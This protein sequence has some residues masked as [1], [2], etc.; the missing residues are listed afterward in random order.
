MNHGKQAVPVCCPPG[1]GLSASFEATW[2]RP[3]SWE[4][5]GLCFAAEEGWRGSLGRWGPG[6]TL[7][8]W[9]GLWG[10]KIQELGLQGAA[11]LLWAFC[12][13]SHVGANPGLFKTIMV[14]SSL[15]SH[16]TQNTQSSQA[17]RFNWT[18]SCR[19]LWKW[20]HL[21]LHA[22][23][24]CLIALGGCL[25]QSKLLEKCHFSQDQTAHHIYLVCNTFYKEREASEKVGR[26][27]VLPCHQKG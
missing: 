15:N 7:D 1:N 26:K 19:G 2:P 13:S 6:V 14:S 24:V 23:R 21:T 20:W 9:P 8:G 10:H 11:Q 5:T 22:P 3:P 4:V 18:H 17:L 27:E 16:P 25:G 12:L